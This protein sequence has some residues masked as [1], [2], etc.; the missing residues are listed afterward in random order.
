MNARGAELFLS[1]FAA[2]A[3]PRQSRK[4]KWSPGA[5]SNL[6]VVSQRTPENS[7]LRKRKDS[8]KVIGSRLATRDTRP[9]NPQEM[10]IREKSD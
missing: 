9:E 10:E 8:K 7:T 2:D 5:M 6:V 4:R 1:I 3:T